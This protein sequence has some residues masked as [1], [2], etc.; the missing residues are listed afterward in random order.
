MMNL[1]KNRR[2][3]WESTDLSGPLPEDVFGGT[4]GNDSLVGT[5]NDDLIEGFGGSDML[6][7]AGGNDILYGGAGVRRHPLRWCGQ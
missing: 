2:Y 7:G 6:Y 1:P 3:F 5:A 4:P